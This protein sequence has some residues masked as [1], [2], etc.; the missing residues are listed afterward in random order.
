MYKKLQKL[1]SREM[2]MTMY[3]NENRMIRMRRADLSQ[4]AILVEYLT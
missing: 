2:F 3:K 4:N 1:K